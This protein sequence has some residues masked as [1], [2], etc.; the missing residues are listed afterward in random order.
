MTWCKRC[1]AESYYQKYCEECKYEIEIEEYI[2]SK[3]KSLKK[4]RCGNMPKIFYFDGNGTYTGTAQVRCS[5]GMQTIEITGRMESS[6]PEVINIWSGKN[7]NP[8]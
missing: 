6:I 4:C 1:G 5:C 7:Q 3:S 8:R 2:A